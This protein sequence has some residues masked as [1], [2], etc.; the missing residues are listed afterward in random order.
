MPEGI[1]ALS[2]SGSGKVAGLRRGS[3]ALIALQGADIRSQ[4][5]SKSTAASISTILTTIYCET[6]PSIDSGYLFR[7]GILGNSDT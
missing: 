2:F 7:D 5:S 3:P 6:M 4:Y 1:S